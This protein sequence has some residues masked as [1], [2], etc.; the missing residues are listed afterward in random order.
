MLCL[1]LVVL[2]F[3]HPPPLFLQEND[4]TEV[5]NSSP[6]RSIFCS[7]LPYMPSD[8]SSS[9]SRGH[10]SRIGSTASSMTSM[11]T[12]IQGPPTL[13]ADGQSTSNQQ[14]GNLLTFTAA[15]ANFTNEARRFIE[16]ANEGQSS[17]QLFSS[18]F[19]K[20]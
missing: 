15:A 6:T 1:L 20:M 16:Q 11:C 19:H 9:T 2:A 14:V 7:P 18:A 4:S 8:K 12:A 13:V 5:D 3:L 17:I 10:H